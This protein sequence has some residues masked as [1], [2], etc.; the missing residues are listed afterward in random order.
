MLRLLS[1]L[2]PAADVEAYSQ[3]LT[4]PLAH[5]Q[6]VRP[7]DRRCVTFLLCPDRFPAALTCVHFWADEAVLTRAHAALL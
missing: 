5:N 1:S 3:S 2:S 7:A 4:N 6:P